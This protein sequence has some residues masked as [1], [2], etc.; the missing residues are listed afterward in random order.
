MLRAPGIPDV[1]GLLQQLMD[2]SIERRC[3]TAALRRRRQADGFDMGL[4]DHLRNRRAFRMLEGSRA[5]SA[6]RKRAAISGGVP[7]RPAGMS[8]AAGR[9]GTRS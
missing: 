8:A 1:A 2:W 5:P 9:S 4:R 7:E 3:Y 6:S